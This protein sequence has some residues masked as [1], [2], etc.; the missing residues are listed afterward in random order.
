MD[1]FF[2]NINFTDNNPAFQLFGQRLFIDQTVSEFLIEF[3]L[4]AFSPKKIGNDTVFNSIL[5]DIDYIKKWDSEIL[6]Y[7]PKARLNLK[8]FSFLGASSLER[9]HIAHR[10]H[11][12][13]I[14]R[15]LQ[16]R[17]TSVDGID[18]SE[19]VKTINDL[20]LGFL[21]AGQGRTF[22]AQ[23]FLPITKSFLAGESI[24]KLSQ[25]R[26]KPLNW[27]DLFEGNGY[28]VRN[29]HA[30]LARGGEVIYLQICNAIRKEPDK[31]KEWNKEFEFGFTAEEQDP[32]KLH[33]ELSNLLHG[34]INHCPQTL[35]ELA[36]FVDTKIDVDTNLKTDYIGDND[37]K[38]FK[39]EFCNS[40]SW[41]EGY[42]FAVE[43]CRI[44][45]SN[46]GIIDKVQV[47]ETAFAFQVIRTLLR[48]SARA[49]SS[50]K[51]NFPGYFMV[52][53]A[54]ADNQ[55]IIKRLS[56][57]SVKEDEK[58]IYQALRN[59]NVVLLPQDTS[60]KLKTLKNSDKDYG[61]K[62]FLKISKQVGLIVPPKG[63]GARFVINDQIIR[64][65]VLSLISPGERLTYSSF[66]GLMERQYGIIVDANGIM[67]VNKIYNGKET[68][69][70]SGT[71]DWFKSALDAAGF[72]IHLSD[73]FA[74]VQNSKE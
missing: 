70:D 45:K 62:L 5:P 56:Q 68:V 44:L 51:N 10:N 50:N 49:N 27:Q 72:L 6:S 13:Y 64:Y 67:K 69:V 23:S 41:Q 59:E 58:S 29:K 31:I 71:D 43:L 16:N 15:E 46:L 63:Q 53:S 36:D 18:K 1:K 32:T 19:I 30:F 48:S 21:Y 42:L 60:Q 26:N 65:L 39:T 74:L 73:S 61:G 52:V 24:W 17:I 55:S 34:F 37:L 8:L 38:F 3:L 57:Q 35:D 47:L 9:R 33:K 14:V 11:Y 28:F 40:E 12:K 54:P 20:L 22:S 4:V 7:A 25:A 2:P 66:L